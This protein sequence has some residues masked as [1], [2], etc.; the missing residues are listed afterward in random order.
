MYQDHLLLEI[1]FPRKDV[2]GKGWMHGWMG[3]GFV[4]AL[5]E[6][7]VCYFCVPEEP[8]H[9]GSLWSCRF[10]EQSIREIWARVA[11]ENTE[12]PAVSTWE[13]IQGLGSD[14]VP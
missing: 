8:W 4:I 14:P 12:P 6:K 9:S 3:K 2:M 13:V 10:R 1:T 11:L 5:L 7:R